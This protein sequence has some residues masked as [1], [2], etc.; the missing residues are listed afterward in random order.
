MAWR[1]LHV[2]R[3][4]I[5]RSKLHISVN[6]L[7][8]DFN[9]SLRAGFPVWADERAE[10]S[11]AETTAGTANGIEYSLAI[12]FTCVYV[13]EV[14]LRCVQWQHY[15]QHFTAIC[16]CGSFFPSTT[17]SSISRSTASYNEI[18]TIICVS[19]NQWK[20]AIL[21]N[22]QQNNENVTDLSSVCANNIAKFHSRH[23]S[24]IKQHSSKFYEGKVEII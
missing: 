15:S 10:S 18:F 13:F 12:I 2:T 4:E 19:L 3:F 7:S 14:C 11:F 22:L 24:L 23:S 5:E 1:E 6:S 21:D 8:S 20:P 17:L 16:S 9:P